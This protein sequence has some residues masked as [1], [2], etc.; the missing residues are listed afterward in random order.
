[1]TESDYMTWWN[2]MTYDPGEIITFIK[3]P[4]K[5]KAWIDVKDTVINRTGYF[6]DIMT[7]VSEVGTISGRCYA[8]YVDWPMEDGDF[9][10]LRFDFSKIDELNIYVHE[11]Q[12]EIGL[13]MNSWPIYP[14]SLT[15][16]G[17][18]EMTAIIQENY[19]K[20]LKENEIVECEDDEEHSYPA[21]VLD[22]SRAYFRSMHEEAGRKGDS[23]TKGPV[24][25]NSL[26]DIIFIDVLLLQHVGILETRTSP[27]QAETTC[28]SASNPKTKASPNP[29][30]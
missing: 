27:I 23:F 4:Q 8:V 3:P 22:W 28:P 17:G 1:M 26:S 19:L 12:D 6:S 30:L 16:R 11:R 5:D 29:Q 20:S 2:E 24:Y 10:T 9:F 14:E 25:T 7:T 15:I 21:C 13:N 18:A